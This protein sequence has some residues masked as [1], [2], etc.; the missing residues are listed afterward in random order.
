MKIAR[1]AL[2]HKQR[3][4]FLS[5]LLFCAAL[6]RRRSLTGAAGNGHQ[7]ARHQSDDLT[8]RKTSNENE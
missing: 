2:H 5:S 1:A 7:T 4:A 6:Q 3:R 8:F